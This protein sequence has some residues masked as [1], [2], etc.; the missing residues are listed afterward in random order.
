MYIQTAMTY[1]W[2]ENKNRVN[3]AKHGV[4]FEIALLVF[5][6]PFAISEQDRDVEGEQRWVIIGSALERVLVVAYAVRG[7]EGEITR[8]ISARKATPSERKSYEKEATGK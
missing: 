4:P 3:A 1:E 8:I 2:D 5:D 7:A 6:D